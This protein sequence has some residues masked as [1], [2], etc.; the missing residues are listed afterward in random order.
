MYIFLDITLLSDTFRY[1]KSKAGFTSCVEN[2]FEMVAS[3]IR[4]GFYINLILF[5]C[6]RQI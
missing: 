3:N 1:F 2:Q 5:F 4:V 6:G